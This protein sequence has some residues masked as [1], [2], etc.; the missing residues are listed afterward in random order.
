MDGRE[1]DDESDLLEGEN[2]IEEF[3]DDDGETNDEEEGG[4]K[5]EV[6]DEDI[7]VDEDGQYN[8]E[9]VE[10]QRV[11]PHVEM[12]LENGDNLIEEFRH[13]LIDVLYEEIQ[14]ASFHDLQEKYDILGDDLSDFQCDQSLKTLRLSELVHIVKTFFSEVRFLINLIEVNGNVTEDDELRGVYL[15]DVFGISIEEIDIIE[16]R[17]VHQFRYDVEIRSVCATCN[18]EYENDVS[19]KAEYNKYCGDSAYEY[20][21]IMSGAA[22]FPVEPQDELGREHSIVEGK[23][24]ESFLYFRDFNYA[25]ADSSS[26]LLSW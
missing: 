26:Q 4:E 24:F 7:D 15:D 16:K 14:P 22:F 12:S 25:Y 1:N 23:T 8:D 20:G 9:L 11:S 17:L 19:N 5:V 2:V 10:N 3:R 6:E 18:E 21:S 13:E